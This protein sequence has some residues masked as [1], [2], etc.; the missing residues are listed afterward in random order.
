[1]TAT[2]GA[3]LPALPAGIAAATIVFAVGMAVVIAWVERRR[4]AHRHDT[5]QQW[6][7]CSPAGRRVRRTVPSWSH[8]ARR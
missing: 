3:W 1:M 4:G 2:V 6:R 7:M 8:R 5:V